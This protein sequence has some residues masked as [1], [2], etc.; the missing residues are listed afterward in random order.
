MRRLVAY[1]MVKIKKTT[2]RAI[3][4]VVRPDGGRRNLRTVVVGGAATSSDFPGAGGRLTGFRARGR[5]RPGPAPGRAVD[6]GPE[7]TSAAYFT[8]PANR[9]KADAPA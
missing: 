9:G 6:R 2:A 5:P 3:A 4:R 1:E 8:D 7:G